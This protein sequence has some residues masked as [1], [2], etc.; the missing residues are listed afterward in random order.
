[1]CS[2]DENE[3]RMINDLMFEKKKKKEKNVCEI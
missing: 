3:E 2:M 1:M